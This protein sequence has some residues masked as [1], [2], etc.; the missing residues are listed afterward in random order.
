LELGFYRVQQSGMQR[1]HYV[2]VGIVQIETGEVDAIRCQKVLDGH[3]SN[4]SLARCPT[5]DVLQVNSVTNNC[6]GGNCTGGNDWESG[7][8]KT[9]CKNT[10]YI[11]GISKR[12]DGKIKS[13]MCCNFQ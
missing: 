9:T 7:L 12:S 11:K 10:Q 2:A 6:P 8:A 1:A 3:I 5:A 13:I 4:V